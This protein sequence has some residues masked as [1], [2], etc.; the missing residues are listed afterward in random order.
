M[1]QLGILIV[2]AFYTAAALGQTS[3]GIGT[4][5]PHT[6]A[7]LDITSNNKGLLVPRMSN[8]A[9]LS[10]PSP[11]NGLLVYDSS[12]HRLYQ[13]QDGVWRYM[14]TNESWIQ[15][16]TRN[17][18]YNS[19]D[20]IG[21]GTSAP[22]EKLDV[23]GNIRSRQG[24]RADNNINAS[25]D[26]MAASVT[27]TAN[28]IVNGNASIG[29]SLTTY[30]NIDLD[31]TGTT[32]QLQT[33]ADKKAFFQLSG[34]DLRMGT[35]SGNSSGKTV[36]RVNGDDVASIDR[37][38]NI[39]LL[40]NRFGYRGN[41]TVGWKVCRFADPDINMLPV[42]FGNIAA[43]PD[44]TNSWVT[45]FLLTNEFTKIS[46]GQYDIS[47]YADFVTPY[48][49]IIIT[50]KEPNMLCIATWVSMRKFRVQTFTRTGARADCAFSFVVSDPLN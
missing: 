19:S 17:W 15:S 40:S 14:L 20:S 2:I 16:S 31:A 48:S 41:I 3:V 18:M 38:A 26:I 34:N 22:T 49:A 21:I 37:L 44:Y 43:N 11:A 12:F 33:N 46:T 28:M 39:D 5:A 24:V 30:G 50:P 47:F 25:G 36:L 23:N 29:S 32:L 1:K 7:A 35:N 27:S 13:F 10:I 42:A 6:S 8:T 9:R 4:N 45:P